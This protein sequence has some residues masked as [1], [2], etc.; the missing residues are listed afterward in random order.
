[1]PV[2]EVPI[3]RIT[4]WDGFHHVFAEVLGFPDYYGR[5]LDAWIDCLTYADDADAGMIDSALIASDG[6]VLTL[7][8]GILGDFAER[9]PEQYDALLDCASFV[10]WRRIEAGARPIIALSFYK[11]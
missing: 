6:D 5:N 7:Q 11:R 9:C 1:V 3:D 10:N 2:V 8:L 4:D